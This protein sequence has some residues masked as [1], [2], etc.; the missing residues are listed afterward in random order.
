MH[1]AL[2]KP[3]NVVIVEAYP[4]GLGGNFM[5]QSLFVKGLDKKQF[6][7]RILAPIDGVSLDY[8]R[9]LGIQCDVIQSGGRLNK[10]GRVILNV[11][12]LSRFYLI[13]DLIMYNFQVGSYLKEIKADII[14]T[15]SVRSHILICLASFFLNIPSV[16]YI[17]GELANPLIDRFC[18]FFSTK[19]LFFTKQNSLEKY[20][21]LVKILRNKVS[22]LGIGLDLIALNADSSKELIDLSINK[23]Y[24]NVGVVGQLYE[25]KGQHLVLEAL[26]EIVGDF[27]NICV[28]FIGDH[29]I[30]KYKPYRIF[31]EQLSLKLNLTRNII[32]TGWRSDVPAIVSRM[33]L[34]I[35][36]SYSEGFGRAVLEA[37]A[38]GKPVIAS[39]VGGLREAISNGENG[40]LVSPGDFLAIKEC[41]IKLLS[42]HELR[43]NIGLAAK[44]TIIDRYLIDDKV[45]LFG[46]MLLN[47]VC[48]RKKYI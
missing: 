10:Y 4:M 28:Y 31:L 6:N 23:K 44:N 24:F 16:L 43:F 35:H 45:K 15:N 22:I 1:K 5:T 48:K 25:P 29:V 21:L 33:D 38:L 13:R 8:F 18:L 19:V 12:L 47:L 41:W 27:P 34:L 37:M 2:L 30:D 9:S 3:I 7:I 20:P 17:K 42:N 39:K 40:F 32:F 26:N 46:E 14:Y 36:P 11:G